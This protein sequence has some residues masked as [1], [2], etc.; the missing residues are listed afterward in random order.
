M[1]FAEKL[2]AK[3]AATAAVPLPVVEAPAP[4]PVEQKAEE[5]PVGPLSFADK[6]AAKKAAIAQAVA[7]PQPEQ[8]PFVMDP[9]RL[10]EDPAL[11]QDFMDISKRIYELESLMEDD[12]KSS[13]S[14]LKAALK[15]NPAASELLLHEDIGKMVAA[16]YKMRNIT[17]VTAEK[18]PSAKKPKAKEVAL[19]AEQ[20]AAAWDEL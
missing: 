17:M 20:I 2:A 14:E 18:K 11:A 15:K 1:T 4:A 7:T 13:M 10:P 3:K 12:L 9:D 8:K 6:I 5:K 19:T 16:L